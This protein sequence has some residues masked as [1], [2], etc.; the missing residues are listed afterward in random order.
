MLVEHRGWRI[1]G[2]SV[3]GG[4]IATILASA[5]GSPLPK[6]QDGGCIEFAYVPLGWDGGALDCS[7]VCPR[8]ANQGAPWECFPTTAYGDGI[9]VECHYCE[10]AG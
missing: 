9:Y 4:A 7:V 10:D 3:F 2:A 5:C 6:A 8:S 1:G